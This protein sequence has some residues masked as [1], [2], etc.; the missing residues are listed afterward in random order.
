MNYN[1]TTLRHEFKYII[2]RRTY[3]LIKENLKGIISPDV[4]SIGGGYHI[5]S[6]YFDDRYGSA[7]DE[8]ESGI[9]YR[10]KYRIRVYEKSDAVIKLERKEKYGDYIAKPTASLSR[11]E[12]YR[13]CQGDCSFLLTRGKLEQDFYCEVKTKGL[14]PAVIVDYYREAFVSE[15]GNV[16]ITFDSELQAGVNTADIFS[17]NV[18]LADCFEPGSLLLEVK[19]DDYIPKHISQALQ[20]GSLT[21]TANSKYVLCRLKQ[22]E[23][24]PVAE[25]IPLKL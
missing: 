12:F 24:Y 4:H 10:R 7:L 5:R 20:V 1:G 9:M 11:D 23:L 18:H 14:A 13:I 22:F 15:T 6:L 19:Y 8:K 3:H 21:K 2:D 16:R 17:D 25:H